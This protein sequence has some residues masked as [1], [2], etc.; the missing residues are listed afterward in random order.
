MIR[1]LGNICPHPHDIIIVVVIEGLVKEEW[2]K[3][4]A[5]VRMTVS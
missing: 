5:E 3:H 2:D 1:N 4:E